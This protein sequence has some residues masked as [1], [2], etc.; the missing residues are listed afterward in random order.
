MHHMQVVIQQDDIH[1]SY[2]YVLKGLACH[3]A[4][5]K[6]GVRDLVGWMCAMASI[7]SLPPNGLSLAVPGSSD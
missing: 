5:P 3:A 7:C 6:Q 4:F 2:V 1:S